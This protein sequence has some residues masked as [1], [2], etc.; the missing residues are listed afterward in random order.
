M[1]AYVFKE[2]KVVVGTTFMPILLASFWRVQQDN[3]PITTGMLR[4]L[5]TSTAASINWK[6]SPVGRD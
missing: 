5:A 2:H 3:M 4:D 6:P 1:V